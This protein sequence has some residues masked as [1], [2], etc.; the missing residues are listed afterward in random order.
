RAMGPCRSGAARG[1]QGFGLGDV[2]SGGAALSRIS[3]RSDTLS[4][5]AARWLGRA[6]GPGRGTR[7]RAEMADPLQ[8]EISGREFQRRHLSQDRKSTHLNSSHRT[9]SYAVFCLKKK[10]K[11]KSTLASCR[12]RTPISFPYNR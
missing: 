11:K 3:R 10:K 7:R 6:R 4:R 1:V 9:I 5:S 2:G 8:L 12:R